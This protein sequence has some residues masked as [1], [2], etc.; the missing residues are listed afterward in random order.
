MKG[1]YQIFSKRFE[2]YQKELCRIRN[3]Y[4]RIENSK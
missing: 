3:L 2:A 1:L 4:V